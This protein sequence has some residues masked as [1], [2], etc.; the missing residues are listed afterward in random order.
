MDI[1]HFGH[2]VELRAGVATG[3]EKRQ[4]RAAGRRQ[5]ARRQCRYRCGFEPTQIHHFHDGGEV[6]TV[7]IE[8]EHEGFESAWQAGSVGVDAG[9]TQ[10]GQQS[11]FEF[12]GCFAAR[13]QMTAA[14]AV[15][16]L[17]LDPEILARE[18]DA[19]AAAEFAITCFDRLDIFGQIHQA[20]DFVIVQ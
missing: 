9:A 18:G 15:L 14:A 19:R 6:A 13:R 8:E 5:M 7:R 20:A 10:A 3:A 17:A 12:E 16:L 4:H 11:G 1:R 2:A